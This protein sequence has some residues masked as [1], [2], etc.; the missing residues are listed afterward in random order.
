MDI[1][2]PHYTFQKQYL[3]KLGIRKRHNMIFTVVDDRKTAP[4]GV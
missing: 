4:G 2:L 3:D 1:L